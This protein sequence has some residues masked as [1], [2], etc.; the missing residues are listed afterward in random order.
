MSSFNKSGIIS[1]NGFSDTSPILDMKIKS[2]SDGSVWARIHWIDVSSTVEWFSDKNEVLKCIDKSNRY[3]RMGIVDEFKTSDGIYEF[4]LTYPYLSDTLYNRWTQTSTPNSTT[5]SGYTAVTT[6]WSKYCGPIVLATAG[7][8]IYKCDPNSTWFAPIG[9]T[10]I[11]E[12]GIP[13]ANGSAQKSTELWV[14]IDTL[15]QSKMKVYS[16]FLTAKDFIEL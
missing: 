7:T 2:L 6:A 8:T 14:R 16:N 3:S 13:A 4:M 12:S 15:S 11:W 10:A 1:S 9:Q 5:A